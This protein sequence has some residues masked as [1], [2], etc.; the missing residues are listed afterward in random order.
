MYASLSRRGIV[1]YFSKILSKSIR[2]SKTIMV[3]ESGHNIIL[4]NPIFVSREVK[5]FILGENNDN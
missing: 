5:D 1:N 4:E 2:K 3:P